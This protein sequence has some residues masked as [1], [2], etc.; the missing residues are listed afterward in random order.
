MTLLALVIA[1][2]AIA[3]LFMPRFRPPFLQQRFLVMPLAAGLHLAASAVAL[4]VGPLQHNS[5]IRGGFLRLHR[6]LGRTYV[7]AVIL[8][9]GAAL[10]L[11]TTSQ[12]GVPAHAGFGLLAVLWLTTT[13]VAYREIR[14]GDQLSHRRWMT[15]SYALSFAAVTLRIY[16]PASLAV[17]LPFGPAYQTISW[18]CW[19]PNLVVAE[20]LVLRPRAPGGTS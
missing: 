16:V 5:R 9:G 3:I 7:L 1:A 10:M 20:W 14:R 18:L 8:G 13:A 15:R 17:G 6:W 19:V 12:G 11:A 2:Y 4:A